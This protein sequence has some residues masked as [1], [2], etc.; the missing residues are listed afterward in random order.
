MAGFNQPMIPDPPRFAIRALTQV[1]S[2]W[3]NGAR[4]CQRKLAMPALDFQRSAK[5]CFAAGPRVVSSIMGLFQRIRRRCKA[6]E[7]PGS[8]V[9]RLSAK[10]APPKRGRRRRRCARF[11]A[12]ATAAR[13]TPPLRSV[14][15]WG[16]SLCYRGLQTTCRAIIAPAGL[17]MH[18]GLLGVNFGRQCGAIGYGLFAL[19]GSW[20]QPGLG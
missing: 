14:N 11:G 7:S 13:S 4:P 12:G 16:C 2:F 6:A 20:D 17:V 15:P 18:A 10:P 8:P 1:R 5:R 3:S 9:R 19:P